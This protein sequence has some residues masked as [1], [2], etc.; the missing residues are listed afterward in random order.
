MFRYWPDGMVGPLCLRGMR[1]LD[2]YY[3]IRA[4]MPRRAVSVRLLMRRG[5]SLATRTLCGGCADDMHG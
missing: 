3:R 2:V 5:V 4:R 1:A